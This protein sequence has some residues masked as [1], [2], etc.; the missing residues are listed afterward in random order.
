[1]QG[2]TASGFEYEIDERVFTDWRFTVALTGMRSGKTEFEKIE[3]SQKLVTLL[4]GA[5]NLDKYMEHIASKNDGYV[6]T[7]VIMTEVKEILSSQ[8]LKN[9]SSSPTA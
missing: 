3:A 5:E 8:K 7:E 1:M 4:F 2:I 9:S 6:P